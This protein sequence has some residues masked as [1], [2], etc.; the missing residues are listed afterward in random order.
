MNKRQKFK[1]DRRELKRYEQRL[2]ARREE[3]G[4]QAESW[5]Q[6]GRKQRIAAIGESVLKL[7]E[8]LH[9]IQEEQQRKGKPL[10]NGTLFWGINE[11]RVQDTDGRKGFHYRIFFAVKSEDQYYSEEEIRK[12]LRETYAKMK[13]ETEEMY[14][15]TTDDEYLEEETVK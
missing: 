12:E 14:G 1:N 5:S 4:R 3:I 13:A 9:R 11:E 10:V 2:R 8:D 7:L 6:T 15:E